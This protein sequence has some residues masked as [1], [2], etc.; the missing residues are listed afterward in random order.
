M[1]QYPSQS[2]GHFT[3]KCKP[4]PNINRNGEVDEKNLIKLN[5]KVLFLK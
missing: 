4:V 5:E 1:K 2:G 3:P